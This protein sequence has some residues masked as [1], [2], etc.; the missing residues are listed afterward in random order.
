VHVC[1]TISAPDLRMAIDSVLEQRWDVSK[2]NFHRRTLKISIAIYKIFFLQNLI[3]FASLCIFFIKW[4]YQVSSAI[5][6]SKYYFYY[7]KGRYFYGAYPRAWSSR[8][9]RTI[10]DKVG[11]ERRRTH[12]RRFRWRRRKNLASSAFTS[13]RVVMNWSF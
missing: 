9:G 1:S 11:S 3:I 4:K 7:F 5:F 13:Y 8:S 10:D 12:G 2:L 6:Y